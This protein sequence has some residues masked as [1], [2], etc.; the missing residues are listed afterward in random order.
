MGR[1][2]SIFALYPERK[3]L[4]HYG[5]RGYFMAVHNKPRPTQSPIQP[6]RASVTTTQAPSPGKVRVG[7]TIGE[8]RTQAAQPHVTRE[9]AHR[10]IL[11]SARDVF[12]SKSTKVRHHADAQYAAHSAKPSLK[13]I[14]KETTPEG[15]IPH[16]RAVDFLNHFLSKPRKA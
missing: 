9:T 16:G 7:A 1:I 8:R 2:G 6:R 15:L 3:L 14:T 11:Q 5:L 12:S 4:Y 13:S 10:G